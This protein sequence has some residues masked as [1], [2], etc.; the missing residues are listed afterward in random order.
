MSLAIGMPELLS[1]LTVSL[2]NLPDKRK[3]SNNTKY[4]V[5]E[6]LLSAFSVFFLQS[7]SFLEH[8]RLMKSQKG[9]DNAASLFGI[10]TIPCDNQIRALLDP[11]PASKVFGVFRYVYESLSKT[12]ALSPY[13]CFEKGF[14]LALDGTEYFSSSKIHCSHC[15]H[16]THQ[17]GSTTYF[18]AAITPVLVAPGRAEIISLEPELITPQDGH[19]KQD[20]ENAAAKRWI[21]AHPRHP[22][23]PPVTLLGDDL[24]CNHPICETVLKHGYDFIF[25]CKQTS[26]PELYDW[27]EYLN[28]V[29]EVQTLTQFEFRGPKRLAYHYRFVNQVPLRGLQPALEVNWCEVTVTDTSNQKTLYH[30]AFATCH[31]IDDQNVAEIVRAGRAR[32]KVENEGNNILKTKGYHLEHNFGHG[33]NHLAELLFCLNLLAYLFHTTLDLVH[34]SYRAVRSMLVT[35]QTFFNDLRALTRYLWFESWQTLFEF[36]LCEGKTSDGVNSS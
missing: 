3:T 4:T 32:W 21:T 2:E 20:C 31:Q 19:E 8:Q 13:R 33:Q 1:M 14:L 29:G 34:S 22:E 36:M 26:H 17:N 10:E 11:V 7:R 27:V 35:R 30:N 12:G 9:R 16:R 18:H 15:C 23:S 5:E 25:V 24:Y 6:A 28:R